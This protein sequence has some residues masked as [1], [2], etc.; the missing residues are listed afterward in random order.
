[1]ASREA[2]IVSAARTPIGSFQGALASV[3]ATELGATALSAAIE[4]AGV[5]AE[6]IQE[7]YMG[8]VLSAGLGQA[9]A[10]RAAKGAGI[11]DSAPAVTVSKVCG[12]GL[13]SVIFGVKSL[14]LGEAEIV[15]VGGMENMTDAPYLLP[16]GR[17]GYRMGHG[18]VVD[19]MVHDGLWDP[20]NDFHMGNAAE[21]CAG[22]FTFTR[23]EQDAFAEESYRRAIAAQEEGVFGDELVPVTVKGRKGEVVVGEDEEPKRAN[24][25]K[26]PSLRP[27][28]KKDGTVTAANASKINDGAAALVLA[29]GEAVREKGLKPLARVVSY[30]SH[31]QAPEWFT[32]AP[33]GATMNSL[34]K[35]GL[36]IADIDLFEVNEAFAVVPMA[37]A[38]QC[39]ADLTKTN[40]HGGAVA[41]GHPIGASG[42]RILVTLL[43][44]MKRRGAKRGLASICIGGGEGLALVVEQP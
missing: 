23:E 15:A 39:E 35:A 26:M 42:A 40:V 7:T 27:A 6:H 3:P 11:A 2:F 22:E 10:R 19:S 18:Q 38:R 17:A 32:T 8:N 36:T 44:A 34:K 14:L 13:Q 12:S 31:A 5:Q 30:G 37:W 16:K 25:A 20:Y 24:F 21:M 41:L 1:M 33:V 9:P 29:S 43:H 4:R 28:F